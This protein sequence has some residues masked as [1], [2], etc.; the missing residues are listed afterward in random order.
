MVERATIRHSFLTVGAAAGDAGEPASC[1]VPCGVAAGGAGVP[2][3]WAGWA[4]EEAGWAG[5][6]VRS[7]GRVGAGPA[8]AGPSCVARGCWSSVSRLI[9]AGGGGLAA[10]GPMG[11]LIHADELLAPEAVGS[12]WG[13]GS[14]VR[15]AAAGVGGCR[16]A[17]CWS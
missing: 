8:M 14:G 15:A 13:P 16:C 7:G 10:L 4:D 12:C 6:S 9:S 2:A 3:P 17:V 1:G 5:P 11:A